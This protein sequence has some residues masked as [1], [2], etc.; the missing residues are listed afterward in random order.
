MGN[1][2]Q[3]PIAAIM[4]VIGA[5]IGGLIGLAGTWIKTRSDERKHLKKLLL[6]AAIE[7]WKYVSSNSQS[8]KIVPLD[9]YIAHMMMFFD[10]FL[11]SSDKVTKENVASKL[12][13][14]DDFVNESIKHYKSAGEK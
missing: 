5:V 3:W 13:Q 11:D 9:T 2:A 10:V 14:I 8:T 6:D 12:K 1:E 4:A 7:N